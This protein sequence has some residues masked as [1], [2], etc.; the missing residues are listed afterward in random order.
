M[1]RIIV[2]SLSVTFPMT[3][4]NTFFSMHPRL[5]TNPIVRDLP[6]L[7]AALP[8][9]PEHPE[10]DYLVLDT[11]VVLDLFFWHDARALAL[12]AALSSETFRAVVSEET[13]AE[14][15]DVLMRS[16]FHRNEEQVRAILA[17][18]LNFSIRESLGDTP[19][20]VRCKDP[21]DQKFLSLATK[22]RC[23]L[24]TRDKHLLKI[25]KKM[26]RFGVRVTAPEAL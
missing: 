11:N 24:V 1:A 2:K 21:D 25:A 6:A 5:M 14:L 26:R 10:K 19:C 15:I 18:Y 22:S 4:Q 7:L 23:P 12:L 17:H 3:G 9:M 13:L 16:P 8:Q 20:P